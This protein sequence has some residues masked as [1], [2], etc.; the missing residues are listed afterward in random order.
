MKARQLTTPQMFLTSVVFAIWIVI[1]SI[2]TVAYFQQILPFRGSESWPSTAG[3][4]VSTDVRISTSRKGS[5]SYFPQVNY[6]YRVNGMDYTSDRQRINSPKMGTPAEA[7][8]Y[9]RD[10]PTGKQ[11]KVY[12]DPGLPEQSLLQPG[13]QTVDYAIALLPAGTTLLGLIGWL[14]TFR[15]WRRQRRS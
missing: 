14:F 11:L 1:G 15:R 8:A 2:G 12:Y 9:L 5:H 3:K 6:S 4:V 13:I 10:Y 7:E